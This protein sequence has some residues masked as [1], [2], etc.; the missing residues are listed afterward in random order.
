MCYF[1]STDQLRFLTVIASYHFHYD[2]DLYRVIQ[3]LLNWALSL[4]FSCL[5]RQVIFTKEVKFF[6]A[7]RLSVKSLMMIWIALDCAVQSLSK[8]AL[9]PCT[10]AVFRLHLTKQKSFFVT[11]TRR[12]KSALNLEIGLQSFFGERNNPWYIFGFILKIG[13]RTLKNWG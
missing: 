11:F 12:E 7:F 10:F 8:G 13:T 5:K 6:C 3:T 4:K 9:L 1:L 2:Q